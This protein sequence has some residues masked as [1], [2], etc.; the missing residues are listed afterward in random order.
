M[1]FVYLNVLVLGQC[2][3]SCI[4]L[5]DLLSKDRPVVSYDAL[6]SRLVMHVDDDFSTA[7]GSH[8]IRPALKSLIASEEILHTDVMYPF[9]I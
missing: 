2:H 6:D 5:A 8:P 1:F 4:F 9:I 3:V 7:V